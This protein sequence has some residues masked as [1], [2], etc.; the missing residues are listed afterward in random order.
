[1]CVAWQA[2]CFFT[3]ASLGSWLV[4]TFIK[5]DLNAIYVG[6]QGVT[7]AHAS[8]GNALVHALTSMLSGSY[9]PT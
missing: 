9:K 8:R 1:M 5:H 6:L 2:Y 7:V 3:D 4:Y